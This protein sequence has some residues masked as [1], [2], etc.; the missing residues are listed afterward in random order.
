[1]NNSNKVYGNFHEISYLIIIL[2][3][4]IGQFSTKILESA[5]MLDISDNVIWIR[6]YGTFIAFNIY[7]HLIFLLIPGQLFCA[8]NY[9]L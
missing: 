8:R 6:C 4:I 9:G 2:F 3:G 1:M 7:Q 5:C